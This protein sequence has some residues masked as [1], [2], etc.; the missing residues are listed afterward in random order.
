MIVNKEEL[1]LSCFLDDLMDFDNL[2]SGSSAFSEF[3]LNIWM[4]K[5]DVRFVV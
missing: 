2:I 1:E 3:S 5:M 4:F